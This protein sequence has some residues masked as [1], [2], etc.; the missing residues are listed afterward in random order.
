L[1]TMDMSGVT[2]FFGGRENVGQRRRGGKGRE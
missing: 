2:S 1:G